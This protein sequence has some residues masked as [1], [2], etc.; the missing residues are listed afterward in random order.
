VSMRTAASPVASCGVLRMSDERLGSSLTR[1][2]T[3]LICYDG[4][5]DADAAIDLAGELFAGK[6]TVVLTVW[7]GL[8]EVLARAGSGFGVAALDF[9]QIDAA[10]EQAANECAQAG[11]DRAREAGLDPQARAAR[12]DATIWETILGCAYDVDAAAIVL[13]SR[14]LTGVKS[15]L[16]G[17]VS[18]AVL[19]HADR[20]VLV[21]PGSD[22]AIERA[23]RQG[24]RE[25]AP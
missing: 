20:A 8:L 21:V 18:H 16:L 4:S 5:R 15:M 12:R 9:E 2:M 10:S 6:S 3:I 23:G 11:A 13:G 1:A 17:S 24:R 19:Q 25:A 22:V 14:G 7:D